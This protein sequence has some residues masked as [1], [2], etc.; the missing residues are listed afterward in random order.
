M[1]HHIIEAAG[2]WFSQ[3]T[4]FSSTNKTDRY[5]ITEIL[6]KGTLST[7]IPPYNTTRTTPLN[8]PDFRRN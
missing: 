4:P 1:D 3:G 2:W 7:I 8:R 6:L 5:D